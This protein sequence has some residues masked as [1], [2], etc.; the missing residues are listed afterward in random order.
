M[1]F[2]YWLNVTNI[3]Y[4]VNKMLL[5]DGSAENL[6]VKIEPDEDNNINTYWIYLESTSV[7]LTYKAFPNNRQQNVKTKAALYV[8]FMDNAVP[9]HGEFRKIKL[10]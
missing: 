4:T 5:C 8:A 7:Y 3:Q 9:G 2:W 1:S 10:I 6:K